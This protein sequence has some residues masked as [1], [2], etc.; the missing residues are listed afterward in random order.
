MILRGANA[1]MALLFVFAVVV[2]YN[3]P[4]PGRWMAIYG[5]AA[6]VSALAALGKELRLAPVVIAAVAIMWSIAII[7]GGAGGADYLRMFDA[8]EMTSAPV[9]E[10]REATGLLIVA[11]WMILL[12]VRSRFR[13]RT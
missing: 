12:A 10:A 11:G 8:W 7:A 4:D 6:A 9:E 5:A 13:T 1:A 2:Q 3:D